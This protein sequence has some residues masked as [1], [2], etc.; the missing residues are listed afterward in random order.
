MTFSPIFLV[1][2]FFWFL[3]FLQLITI[4]LKFRSH[5]I[6]SFCFLM[7]F[8]LFFLSSSIFIIAIF[9]PISF[10]FLILLSVIPPPHPIRFA[11]IPNL[12]LKL[13]SIPLAIFSSF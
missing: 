3:V 12:V 5:F 13:G 7:L 1:I 2:D 11:I 9:V 8:L 6:I 4:M 10:C